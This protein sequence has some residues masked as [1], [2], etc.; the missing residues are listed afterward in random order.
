MKSTVELA[1]SITQRPDQLPVI[2]SLR[3][4]DGLTSLIA[5][6]GGESTLIEVREQL[7]KGGFERPAQEVNYALNTGV[8][9]NEFRGGRL[10]NKILLGIP[11]AYGLK[12][13]RTVLIGLLLIPVFAGY[14]L[15][16]IYRGDEQGGI[17]VLRNASN[18]W[19]K[20]VMQPVLL[21]RRNCKPVLAVFWFSILSAFRIGWH[22]F[23]VGDWIARLQRRNYRLEAEG[24]TR[25]ASG[26][27]SLISVYLLAL[28]IASYISR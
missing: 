11:F 27:Q 25:T 26:V 9:G 16:A 4:V 14:Y 20:R 22:D 23:N 15:L 2:S 13:E 6:N 7:K 3:D 19:P 12:P 24:W 21:H 5:L 1:S 17:W 10:L 8:E 18:Q 28:A